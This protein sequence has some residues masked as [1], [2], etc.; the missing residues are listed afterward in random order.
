MLLGKILDEEEYYV[1]FSGIEACYAITIC[2]V[3]F[4]LV[5]WRVSDGKLEIVFCNGRQD[6]PV[7]STGKSLLSCLQVYPCRW[8]MLSNNYVEHVQHCHAPV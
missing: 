2:Y 7:I 8:L 3:Y 5:R 1:L 6:V 4:K